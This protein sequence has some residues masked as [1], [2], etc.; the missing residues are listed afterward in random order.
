[1][2]V[3]SKSSEG[4]HAYV[5]FAEPLDTADANRLAR[6]LK[7]RTCRP[8][9][10]RVYPSGPW[11][12]GLVLGLPGCG[13]K[14]TH[15]LWLGAGGARLCA[16]VTLEPLSPGGHAGTLES[17]PRCAVDVFAR[18]VSR[19]DTRLARP[20]GE[21]RPQWHRPLPVYRS[22]LDVLAEN[23]DFVR[24][25]ADFPDAMTYEQWFSLATILAV[26]PGGAQLF[27]AISASDSKR[28]RS[29]EIERKLS[30]IR[31]AP[32]HCVNVG[33]HCP[34][35]AECGAIGVRSPAGLPYKLKRVRRRTGAA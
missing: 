21:V 26:F 8:E 11:G 33:W 19:L 30:S 35:L 25:C 6:A 28:Y 16:S 12:D 4:F 15:P 24:W 13:M 7:D 17:W 32:R 31:G 29:R 1:L 23:C 22:E 3:T 5:L 2:I 34:K 18:A 14:G 20:I 27:D 9:I 10:D